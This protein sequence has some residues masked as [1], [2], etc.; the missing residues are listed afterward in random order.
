MVRRSELAR[1]AIFRARE[2]ALLLELATLAMDADSAF[3]DELFQHASLKGFSLGFE[4]LHQV[5]KLIMENP[6]AALLFQREP[7]EDTRRLSL[8]RRNQLLSPQSSGWIV[9]ASMNDKQ[10]PEPPL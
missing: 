4:S 5:S 6:G 9:E 1:R 8:S 2:G 10:R 7:L 3:A